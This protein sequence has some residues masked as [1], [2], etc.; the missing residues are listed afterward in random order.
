MAS[1]SRLIASL[2]VSPVV[3]APGATSPDSSLGNE[4]Q[5]AIQPTTLKYWLMTSGVWVLQGQ[6]LGM[7]GSNNLSELT[8]PAIAR[9]NLGLADLSNVSGLLFF[10]PAGTAGGISTDFVL[11]AASG[12]NSGASIALAK[13]GTVNWRWMHASRFGEASN[14]DLVLFGS[15]LSAYALRINETNG[16]ATLTGNV[17]ITKPSP[18]LTLDATDDSAYIKWSNNG[19][20][21]WHGSAV[22]GSFVFYNGTF[23]AGVQLS[24]QSATSWTSVSDGRIKDKIETLDVRQMLIDHPEFRAVRFR[25]KLS[26]AT[27]IGGIAQENA[28]IF[29][30]LVDRGS[31]GELTLEQRPMSTPGLWKLIYD[32]HGIVALH[33][34]R[35]V[36]DYIESLEARLAALES[37]SAPTT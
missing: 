6:L 12:S 34:L 35:Q 21:R 26:D 18:I 22:T 28:G 15:G 36:W 5:Y 30:E 8:G 7:L 23:T 32:R 33:G 10:G 19:A 9:S 37:P 11:N 4:G 27:E 2:A 14:N 3:V 13:N 31:D 25:N 17:V 16:L 29:P 20:A 1:V 24:S